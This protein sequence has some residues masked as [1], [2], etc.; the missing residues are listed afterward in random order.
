MDSNRIDRSKLRAVVCRLKREW[1]CT[2]LA[3]ATDLL[4]DEQVVALVRPYVDLSKLRPDVRPEK[5]L[6]A[7][8]KAFD[9]ASRA[10]KYYESFN[11]NSSNYMES[12]GG[13][14]AWCAE[15]RRLLDRCAAAEGSLDPSEV[16][17]AFETVFDL[18]DHIDEG[19]DDVIFFADEGG[20]WQVG[21]DWK[22][23]LPAW[24]KVLAATAGPVEFA[25]RVVLLVGSHC[26]YDRD[27]MLSAAR[28]PATPDQRK[29]LSLVAGTQFDVAYRQQMIAR[30]RRN[31][32]RRRREAEVARQSYLDSIASHEAA[33]WEKLDAL[34]TSRKQSA[35]DEAIRLLSD[36]RDLDVRKQA[37]LFQSRFGELLRRHS[38]KPSF[39]WRLKNSG[40]IPTT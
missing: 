3:E 27:K 9:A 19:N 29:E 14:V 38:S 13:T 7:D 33:L 2:V 16:R 37:G 11:V 34:V 15:C 35:Y 5:G 12:S 36:L 28:K 6:L 30:R 23:I 25:E 8:A 22:E 10:R 18:L 1:A 39:T 26:N 32:E 4:T 40:L 20:S 21:V 17:Q 24:F 31:E